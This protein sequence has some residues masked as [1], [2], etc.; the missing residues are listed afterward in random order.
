MIG[1]SLLK[2]DC[3]AR[4][5]RPGHENTV[6]LTT[7]PVTNPARM[8]PANVSGGIIAFLNACFQMIIFPVTPLAR[9]SLMYSESRTFSIDDLTSRS[10][11]A[12]GP[13]P[14]LMA[15]SM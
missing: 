12:E 7:V 5:P 10:S 9:A 8:R 3:T 11:P 2:I 1:K 4:R 6:S 13:E 14:R 15:G